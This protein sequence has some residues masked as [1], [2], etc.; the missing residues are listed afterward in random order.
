MPKI[1]PL[2]TL[3]ARNKRAA[4]DWSRSLFKLNDACG[5]IRPL[6]GI[7]ESI[8]FACAEGLSD[9]QKQPE[10]VRQ[11]VRELLCEIISEQGNTVDLAAGEGLLIV[12]YVF[13]ECP[14]LD[15][16]AA[17]LK[18]NRPKAVETLR[19]IVESVS[20]SNCTRQEFATYMS[21]AGGVCEALKKANAGILPTLNM[22]METAHA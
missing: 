14:T 3:Q 6:P 2:E 9:L 10:P 21:Q 19:M 8:I 12:T 17:T 18:W 7:Y 5:V 22:D 11:K 15:Q 13:G 20:A 1:I 16:T 4:F